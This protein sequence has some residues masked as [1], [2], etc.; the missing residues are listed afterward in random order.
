MKHYSKVCLAPLALIL[1]KAACTLPSTQQ[2][3]LVD[4]QAATIIAATLTAMAENEVGGTPAPTR[5]VA[6]TFTPRP[7]STATGA[8]T[9]SITPTY[10]TPM[11]TILQ[12]TNCREGPGQEYQILFTYLA[13]VKLEITGRFASGGVTSG[14]SFSSSGVPM[15]SS[16]ER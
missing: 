6:P 4:D 12:Q 16:F 7:R 2:S 8:A 13:G 10:S 15:A 14:E 9:A 3:P 11:L 1:A 5:Q